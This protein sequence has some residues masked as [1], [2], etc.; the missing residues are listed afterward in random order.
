[1]KK[2]LILFLAFVLLSTSRLWSQD[3]L[4]SYVDVAKEFFTNY[5]HVPQEPNDKLFFS[6]KKSG[7]HVV[8]LDRLKN[9]SI[10]SEQLFWSITDNKYMPLQNFGPGV[11]NDEA[12]KK[13]SEE[14]RFNG[15]PYAYGF[16]RCRYFGYDNWDVDMLKEFGDSIPAN[17]TLLEGLGRAYA[18]FAERYLNYGFGGQP[19]D[20]DTLKRKLGQLDIPGKERIDHFLLYTNKGIDCYKILAKRNPG[21]IMLVGTPEMKVLNEQFHQ[22]QQLLSYGYTKEAA[23]VLATVEKNDIYHS[24]GFV[25]LNACPLNSILI[26]YGDN[27]TYALWYAQEK[28]GFRKD[29]TVI[30]Y[31]LLGTIP[32]LLMLKNSKKLTVSISSDYFRR[33]TPDYFY[34]QND[35]TQATEISQPLPLFI[36]DLIKVKYPYARDGDTLACYNSKVVTSDVNLPRLRNICNQTN[37][38]PVMQFEVGEYMLLNALVVFDI[39]NN[40][41]YTRPICT[42]AQLDAL[43]PKYMQ[44]EGCVYRVLPIDENQVDNKLRLE[45]I[46][47]GKFLTANY[48]P[49]VVRYGEQLNKRQDILGGLHTR[50]FSEL[51]R[52]NLSLK[53]TI[54]ARQWAAKYLAHPQMKNLEVSYENM[55]LAEALLNTGH[56]VQA[57][58]QLEQLAEKLENNYKNYSAVEYYQSKEGVMQYVVYFKYLLDSKGIHSEKVEK[59]IAELK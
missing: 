34:F 36:S 19:Y 47:L 56:P 17:D 13:I 35:S 43:P 21:Y 2:T 9:D 6:K 4:P 10:K 23:Q 50:M 38:N 33:V 27:D 45:I 22:Y 26:S 11:S 24:I 3:R 57:R 14:L 7:W 48:Q 1:M 46:S 44:S 16:E 15:S 58:I 20:D 25:Y 18:N 41:L 32:Y 5:S 59:I 29:V 55:E 42:T 31:Q 28:E 51:I 8:I 12:E 37:F 30:N 39:L 54:R 52:R 53:D 40:Y 49:V